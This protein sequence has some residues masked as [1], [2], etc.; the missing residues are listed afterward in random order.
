MFIS[1][2][3]KVNSSSPFLSQVILFFKQWKLFFMSQMCCGLYGEH[4]KVTYFPH[5]EKFF[6]APQLLSRNSS[7]GKIA[8][9]TP[10]LFSFFLSH[11]QTLSP[12]PTNVSQI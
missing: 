8:P 1:K 9:F 12:L 3:V 6:L 7:F 10:N 2:G 11:E 5:F 4:K